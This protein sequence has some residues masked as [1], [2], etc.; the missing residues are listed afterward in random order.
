MDDDAK[1]HK[2]DHADKVCMYVSSCP[3]IT[4]TA[5]Q[6]HSSKRSKKDKKEKKDKKKKSHKHHKHSEDSS[7]S[8]TEC[9]RY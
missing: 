2:H 6:E 5:A 4:A 1:K 7:V 9:C 3:I 8:I